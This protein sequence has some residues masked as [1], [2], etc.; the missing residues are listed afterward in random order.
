MKFDIVPPENPLDAE[1]AQEFK[2]VALTGHPNEVGFAF[3]FFQR[4]YHAVSTA[5]IIHLRDANSRTPH[6]K[7]AMIILTL[8]PFSTNRTSSGFT[9]QARP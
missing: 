1:L 9:S 6:E 2:A 3:C 5:C 8:P 7:D 4:V